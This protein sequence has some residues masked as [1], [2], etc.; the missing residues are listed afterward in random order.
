[1]AS[2]LAQTRAMFEVARENKRVLIEAFM[3][4]AHPLTHAVMHAVRS[5]AIGELRLIRTSFCYHT[6]RVQDQNIRFRADLAGG[7]L[8]DV[9]CYCLS[10]SRLFA[11]AEPTAISVAGH[12]HET[13]VD[14]L[15]AATLQFPNGIFASF[16]CGMRVHADNTAYLCGSEGYIEIPIPWKPPIEKAAFTIARS[17][18]PRMDGPRKDARPPRE[19]K[20]VDAGMDLYAL[21]ADAF[22]ETVLDG[23]PPFVSEQD[24]LGN[25]AVLD[26]MRRQINRSSA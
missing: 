12:V 9:G 2:D 8:M 3:Y 10:F 11:G 18:P 25:M 24:T 17:T 5:G 15:A 23:A 16:T 20:I 26:E 19:T 22:A 1:M 6:T 13:G 21:E 7:G 14:D 4:R